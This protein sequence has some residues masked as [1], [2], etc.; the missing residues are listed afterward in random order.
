MMK[1]VALLP[2]Q[3]ELTT[4]T[5]PVLAPAGTV[6]C[7]CVLLTKVT[8]VEFVP[9]N[10][11]VLLAVNPL[12]LIVT[13]VPGVPLAGE[14]LLTEGDAFTVMGCVADAVQPLDPVTV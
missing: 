10:R 3:P 9:L 11:T 6:A 12:P 4:L 8:F 7:N 1:L 2:V 14:K 5:T 13:N